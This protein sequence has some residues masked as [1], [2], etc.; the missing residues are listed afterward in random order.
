[1]SRRVVSVRTGHASHPHSHTYHP[2]FVVGTR[3][4]QGGTHAQL[5]GVTLAGERT[6]LSKIPG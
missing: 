5:M 2:N 3:I 1:M 4:C 6:W